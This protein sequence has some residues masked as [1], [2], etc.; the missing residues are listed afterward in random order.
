ML[1]KSAEHAYQY[2]KAIQAGNDKVA[3]RILEAKTAFQAKVEASFLSYSP[4]WMDQKEKAMEEVLS[5][6]AECCPEFCKL[7]TE[8]SGVIAEVVPGDLFW[9]TGLTKD[10]CNVVKK[11][12]WPGKNKMGR[13]LSALKEIIIEKNNNE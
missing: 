2:K 9:S 11:S 7:L 6:K 10:Q 13:I 8:S 1:H 4:N 12:A 3:E 5:A